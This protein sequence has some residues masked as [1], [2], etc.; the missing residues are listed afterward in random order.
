V[1]RRILCYGVTGSG[2][3]TVAG[4]IGAALGVDVHLAD[5]I[6]WLPGWV[7]RPLEEQIELVDA[8]TSGD[9][10]VLD[11]AYGSWKDRVM[12]RAELVVG[13]DYPRMLSL[14]RVTRRALHRVITQQELFAGN[15][16]SWGQLFS[17]DS[18][19]V[20]HFRSWKRKRATMSAWAADP[21]AP[22]VLL[23][24]R[25]RELDRWIQGLGDGDASRPLA[26]KPPLPQVFPDNPIMHIMSDRVGKA[27]PHPRR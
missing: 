8:A 26:L 3:T 7:N 24:R 18:I 23:F 20:W 13:L 10:W 4:R 2:K 11:S 15:R 1:P 14:F 19:V 25:P 16:E 9:A 5:E 6:G 12:P 27:R 17:R 21:D 22:P